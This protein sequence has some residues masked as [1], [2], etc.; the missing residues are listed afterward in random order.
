[1]KNAI[2]IKGL[3]KNYDNDFKLGEINLDIVT[4]HS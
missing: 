1:M 4:I 3:V 2:E